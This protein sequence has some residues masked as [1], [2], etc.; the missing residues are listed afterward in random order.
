MVINIHGFYIFIYMKRWWNEDT[1]FPQKLTFARD[2]LTE[3]FFWAVGMTSEPNF[4]YSRRVSTKVLS[5]VTT[6]DDV[7]D[8]FGTL[9][10]LEL[11][12]NVVER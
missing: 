7:Y 1:G 10:E 12:T 3:C 5:L 6:I 8:V 4:E 11:F 2:R 9:D